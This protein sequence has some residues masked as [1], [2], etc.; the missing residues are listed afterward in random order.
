MYC[1]MN[2]HRVSHM[3]GIQSTS[4]FFSMPP[5]SNPMQAIANGDGVDFDIDLEFD[6]RDLAHLQV[7]L[8]VDDSNV[9]PMAHP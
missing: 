9:E 6:E 3:G 2:A 8:G 7:L 1:N 4:L 5:A